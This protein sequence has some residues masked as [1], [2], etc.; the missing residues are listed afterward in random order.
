MEAIMTF[1]RTYI[2]S[3]VATVHHGNDNYT[4][5]LLECEDKNSHWAVRATM[6]SGGRCHEHTEDNFH[7]AECARSF[8]ELLLRNLATPVDAHYVFE[9]EFKNRD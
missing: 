6:E 1:E 3:E 8:Y 5:E 2:V 9:D 4:Y 7:E